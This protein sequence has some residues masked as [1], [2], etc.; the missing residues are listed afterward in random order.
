MFIYYVWKFLLSTILALEIHTCIAACRRVEEFYKQTAVCSFQYSLEVFRLK[1]VC[2]FSNK[3]FKTEF[4][5]N[6]F[7]HAFVI[8]MHIDNGEFGP[9]KNTCQQKVGFISQPSISI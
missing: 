5:W 2:W 3:K 6:W 9:H 8:S 7:W 4:A 1:Y